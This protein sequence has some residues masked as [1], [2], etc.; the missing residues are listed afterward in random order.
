[1][2][3]PASKK[4]EITQEQLRDFYAAWQSIGALLEVLKSSHKYD[5]VY[6]LL[7]PV[8]DNL[9]DLFEELPVPPAR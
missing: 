3:A 7:R 4:I 1:M 6:H 9:T 5:N 8:N 2:T